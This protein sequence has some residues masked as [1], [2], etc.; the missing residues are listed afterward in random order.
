MARVRSAQRKHEA[1]VRCGHSFIPS[2]TLCS[3]F[4]LYLALS[5][6]RGWGGAIPNMADRGSASWTFVGGGMSPKRG[7]ADGWPGHLFLCSGFLFL[8]E[9]LQGRSA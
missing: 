4:P 7:S 1:N 3:T 2:I 8:D 6:A 9:S 5:Q